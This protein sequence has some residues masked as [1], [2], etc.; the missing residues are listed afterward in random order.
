MKE[1]IIKAVTALIC[2][3]SICI[4]SSVSIGKYSDAV[5][6]AATFKGAEISADNTVDDS[7][8]DE[9]P[10]D[11]TGDIVE[12]TVAD[13][14]TVDTDATAPD[15]SVDTTTPDTGATPE[16]TTP[17]TNVQ[18]SNDPTTYSKD[19]AVKFYTDSMKKSFNA[20]KTTI[21]TTQTIAISVDYV[22]PGGDNVARLANKIVEK[23][24]N[25]VEDTKAFV[26]GGA[27][28]DP[29]YKADSF[30]FPANLDPKGAKTATVTRKGN[31][32]EVNILVVPEDATLTKFP[33]YNKQCSFPLDLASVDLL[34][35]KVTTADFTYQGT[36]IKATIGQ[37]GYVKRA[38]VYMP[39][40]GEGGGNF[41]GIKGRAEVSGSMTKSATFTY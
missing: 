35:I 40:A 11:V 17:A 9:I 36:K 28:D 41:I 34:G 20:P 31:D 23:Y 18:A 39:L 6:A 27:S 5:K 21:K 15:T 29:Q 38:E 7:I 10:D 25:T 32:Y 24:A 4:T 33:V 26:N 30:A 19:Q 3:V 13:D 22:E 16:E 37:N 8:A 1:T 12:D 2:V 14:S